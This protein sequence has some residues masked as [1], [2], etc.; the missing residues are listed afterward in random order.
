MCKKMEK[1]ALGEMIKLTKAT[2]K[3]REHIQKVVCDDMPS[4]T[5]DKILR[6]KLIKQVYDEILIKNRDLYLTHERML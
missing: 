2:M 5:K 3:K 6:I 1:I 4:E